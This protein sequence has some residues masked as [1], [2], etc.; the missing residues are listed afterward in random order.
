LGILKLKK[1]KHVIIGGGFFGTYLACLLR[2]K[3]GKNCTILV[4]ER[5]KELLKRASFNNQA[6]VHQG[7][8]YP[9][10]LLTA[11]RSRTNFE[12]FVKEFKGCI[13]KDFEQY[14]AIGR[15]NSKVT[16]EQFRNFCKRIGAPLY[17]AP[18]NVK[19]LFDKNMVEEVFL[20]KEY[21]FDPDKLR[22]IMSANLK[23]MKIPIM[24]K[25]EASKVIVDEKEKRVIGVE[26]EDRK[27]G[28]KSRVTAEN[29][30]V[31]TYS[32]INTL[33]AKSGIQK[34]PLKEEMTE[35]AVV[36]V[37]KI[38]RNKGIT[39]MCGPFFS[40]MPFPPYGLHTLSHV[41]YT[42]HYYWNDAEEE[43]DNQKHY[44]DSVKKI[45]TNFVRMVKDASRYVPK[46]SEFKYKSSIW[47]IKT[48]LPRSEVDD[49][50][51]ILF[52]KNTG[53]IKNLICILGGKLDNIYDL[54][55]ELEKLKNA[56]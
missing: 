11:L 39:M 9:R 51:P 41:T 34:I 44:E 28:K 54:G 10:C 33:L 23:K 2:K 46:V 7:Y 21:A 6:R 1:Y 25:T 45:K 3:E 43:M 4:V 22:G 15:K 13:Y 5:E 47:E 14:Y 42:P 20:V 18:E 52:H 37:P 30:F 29:V 12:R 38:F 16:A 36:E 50:R 8:H 24:L 31:C 17:P 32:N 48:I 53:G 27:T 40:F 26:L 56:Q 55:D 35:M 19:S 49:G